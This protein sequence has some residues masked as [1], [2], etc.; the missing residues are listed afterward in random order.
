M[1]KSV[2]AAR[3]QRII[4]I[5]LRD[6]ETPRSD[7]AQMVGCHPTTVTA[8]LKEAG[9]FKGFRP[10]YGGGTPSVA[11]KES[12]RGARLRPRKG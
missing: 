11:P 10:S 7:A 8:V 1:R 3:N 12:A 4:A 9:L 5:Y 2:Y 6:P